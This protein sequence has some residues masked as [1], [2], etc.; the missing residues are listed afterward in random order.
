MHT[1]A[2]LHVWPA[3]HGAPVVPH[4][5]PPAAVQAFDTVGSHG[6]HAPPGGRPHTGKIGVVQAL[7]RQQPVEHAVASQL[8]V[9]FL[10]SSPVVHA[11]P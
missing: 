9:M 7:E 3:V 4:W 1:P 5:H 2:T 6:V 8:H 10:H 11:K